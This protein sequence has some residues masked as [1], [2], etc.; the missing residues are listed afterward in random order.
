M[1]KL[2]YEG[3]CSNNSKGLTMNLKNIIVS[4]DL[5]HH[6]KD[7]VP[8]YKERFDNVLKF[9]APGLAP[10]MKDGKAWHI[11][12][13]GT[14]AYNIKFIRT[15]GFYEE[16]AA[17]IDESGA[18]HI[19]SDGKPLYSRRFLW[20]GNFQ[21]DK[22]PVRKQNNR[23]VHILPNGS[24]LTKRDWKYAGDFKDQIAVVQSDT[25]LSP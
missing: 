18:Y 11:T 17:V 15:F 13:N 3:C 8:I 19:N 22:C 23:Y 16:K 6:L 24:Q 7:G 9:H 25:G 20:T 2:Q 12:V 21:E 10:V 4:P 14:E 5:T 1:Q